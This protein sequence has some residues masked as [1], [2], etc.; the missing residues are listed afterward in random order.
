MIFTNYARNKMI[1]KNFKEGIVRDKEKNIFPFTPGYEIKDTDYCIFPE[2]IVG[3]NSLVIMSTVKARRPD[4]FV[5]FM[6]MP[7]G[8]KNLVA[9]DMLKTS[10]SFHHDDVVSLSVSVEQIRFT[11]SPEIVEIKRIA[12]SKLYSDFVL[13]FNRKENKV[14][15]LG[16]RLRKWYNSYG[17]M[18]S[19]YLDILSERMS[20]I[21]WVQARFTFGS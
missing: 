3:W 10:S 4:V 20:T 18:G 15:K 9:R 14:I 11:P 8:G 16:W 7:A 1:G 12:N 19:V 21:D 13:S 5:G 2:P 6:K 17:N